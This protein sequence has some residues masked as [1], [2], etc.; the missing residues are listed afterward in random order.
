MCNLNTSQMRRGGGRTDLF[1]LPLSRLSSPSISPQILN[2]S[3]RAFVSHLISLSNLLGWPVELTDDNFK[4]SRPPGL[5]L[6]EGYF[7]DLQFVQNVSRSDIEALLLN[8]TFIEADLNIHNR[9]C[10]HIRRTDTSIS[11][12]SQFDEDYYSTAVR[13]FLNRGFVEFD[14][15]SDDIE[16]AKNILPRNLP[17]SYNFP[18]VNLPLNSIKLMQK[19]SNYDQFIAS[20]STLVW[21]ACYLAKLRNKD[22]QII[23]KWKPNLDFTS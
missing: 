23:H 7:Q 3:N 6:A 22:V 20:Q 4:G 21:W 18:E 12:S 9:V 15:F 14:C 17:V 19:M 10:L 11:E 1:S 8:D 13:I 5:F 16:V 2:G